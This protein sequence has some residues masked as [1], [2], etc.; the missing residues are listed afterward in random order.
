MV[1]QIYLGRC[2]GSDAKRYHKILAIFLSKYIGKVIGL[3]GKCKVYDL[4]LW[5]SIERRF[6]DDV[7]SCSCNTHSHDTEQQI[8]VIFK[9]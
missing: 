1:R 7:M 6:Y 4:R 5:S 9:F 8:Y 2:L 3:C